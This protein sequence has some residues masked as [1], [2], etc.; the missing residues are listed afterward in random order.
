MTTDTVGGVWR[1]TLD[2]AR[3]L[4][5]SGAEVKLASFGGL[6]TD[7]QRSEA[8]AISGVSLFSSPYKLEW[9]ESPWDDVA[10]SGRWLLEIEAA[11]RPDL[12]HLN[13]YGHGA[14][15]WKKPVVL[16]AHSC[17]ASWWAAVRRSPLPPEW[18]RYVQ[19]V[20]RALGSVDR[21]TAP[22]AAMAHS[23]RY[24]GIHPAAVDVI[25]NGSDA[26]LFEPAPKKP[27]LLSA[28]RLWDE[29]KN[30]STLCAAASALR[31]PLYLAGP[32]N[33]Q[34]T[35]TNCHHLG[36]LGATELAALLAQAAIYAAP[37]RYEPFGLAVL[38]AALSG[39]ALVLGDIASLRENW[40]GAALF[41][42]PE[43]RRAVTQSLQSLMEDPHRRQ[44]LSN[45]ALL[46]AKTFTID[47]MA[48]GYQRC[49]QMAVEQR[50]HACAS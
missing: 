22:S 49:Y 46:R 42:P 27:F 41:V 35:P 20:K 11:T 29:A 10:E 2:L 38:E 14:L 30:V 21:I 23:L 25:P 12:I 44:A 28:G 45:H 40:D 47:R 43:D 34:A 7:A 13:S 17:V 24:Y 5:K 36:S 26:A 18:T 4:A 1:F 16:T 9:M 19:T 6:P 50:H 3:S 39:C 8:A 48:A 32:R 37:A 15:H 31:W 33:E